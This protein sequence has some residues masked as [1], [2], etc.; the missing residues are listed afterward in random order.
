VSGRWVMKKNKL[1]VDDQITHMK[2]NK[3]ILFNIVDE[4]AAK[5]FLM[6]NNY[7]FK[8]KSYAKNYDKY[9][10]GPNGE[11]YIGLEF[12]YLQEL[13]VIDMHLRKYIIKMTL[14]IEHQLKTQ[15]LRDFMDNDSEDGY[16]IV[17]EFLSAYPRVQ[18]TIISK[19]RN[20]YCADLVQK[21]Q[22][23]FS[24]WNIV[25]VLS[26]GDFIS[27]YEMYYRKY[28][29][30]NSV[31]NFLL[32]VKFLRNAAA[33]NN[34]L[35]NSLKKPYHTRIRANKEINTF[36]SKI[37]GITPLVR[38]K[39]MANPVVHDF[40]V[41]L[42]VFNRIVSSQQMKKYSMA[43]L[44]ELMDNRIQRNHSYFQKNQ[45]LV[46]YYIFIKKIIDYFYDQCI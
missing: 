36:I 27:L 25:E 4:E 45:L 14:D 32:P 34:C 30:P 46:S 38:K 5:E 1:S 31:N 19:G 6:H 33:H 18:D 24:I 42:Y 44:K 11:K 22:G 43:E 29:N 10:Q 8:L 20:S 3:G 2:E 39:K 13:S 16:T 21:Y 35:I 12:A 28:K 7:Y 37:P 15:L 40:V 9:T 26:F 17:A 23:K 41:T